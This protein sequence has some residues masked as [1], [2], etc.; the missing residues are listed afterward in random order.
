MAARQDPG[1]LAL[2][3][4]A[5]A[6]GLAFY[7]ALVVATLVATGGVFEY[8]LDDPYI[9]LALAEQI[10]AG[11][12]GINPGEVS[13]PGSSPLFPLLLMLFADSP[14]QRYLPAFW[15]VVG[16]AAS[17]WLWG[18]LL[19]E[20]GYARAGWRPIGF[21]LAALGPAILLM[22]QVAFLGM[23]HSLHVAA[24]LAVVL[25][26]YRHLSG[27]RPGGMGLILG[28]TLLG[29]AFRF[30]AMAL[31][32]FAAIALFFTD[33]R[34]VG[35]VTALL[36]FLPVVLFMGFLLSLGLDPAPSSVQVKL[37]DGP[38]ASDNPLTRFAINA[39]LNPTAPG[40]KLVVAFV[41][42]LFLLWRFSPG[43][44][45]NRLWKL[46][47]VGVAAGVAHLLA[48]QT[49]WANRYEHYVLVI[50]AAILVMLVP[51][52]QPG[53][54]PGPRALAL[55][56]AIFLAPILVFQPA[57]TTDLPRGARAI[58]TQQGQMAQFAQGVLK[59]PVAVNDIGR[60]AWRNPDYVLD[61]WGLASGEAREIR[62][63]EPAPG[64]TDV[65]TGRHDVPVAMIYE[66]WFEDGIGSDWVRMGQLELTIPM[67]YLGAPAVAFYATNPDVADPLRDAIAAWVPGLRP[68]SRFVWE[69]GM[70]P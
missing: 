6:G 65:L 23:E 31:G 64:W 67:G 25:G 30:E 18:R 10:V 37:S 26:L 17:T 36:A 2:P 60:V 43:L 45:T 28:G 58:L 38:I 68:G 21:V 47:A 39:F 34:G 15:N 5:V 9:H 12:Y 16:L 19:F 69:E 29:S 56:L 4:A 42:G 61:L 52:A 55:L 62:M 3:L 11:N 32:L 50:L 54:T 24:A 70:A 53:P 63:S 1:A 13:S 41:L 8:P 7:A 14:I 22:P 46:A 33:R 57:G 27:E 35:A 40:G 49:G 66:T 20:A 48:G 59:A 51:R 44:R